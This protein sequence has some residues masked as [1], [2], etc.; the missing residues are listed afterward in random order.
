MA[1]I[2]I[3]KDDVMAYFSREEEIILDYRNLNDDAI[4]VEE[5]PKLQAAA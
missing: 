5:P 4:E 1:S 2:T 3:P